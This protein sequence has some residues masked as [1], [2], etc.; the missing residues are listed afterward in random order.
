MLGFQ[1]F[2]HLFVYC[3]Y[4]CRCFV[5]MYTCTTLCVPVFL[6]KNEFTPNEFQCSFA[7][8]CNKDPIIQENFFPKYSRHKHIG[9]KS[10]VFKLPEVCSRL[11]EVNLNQVFNIFLPMVHFRVRPP[12]LSN[13]CSILP[14]SVSKL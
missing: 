2:I 9:K 11:N 10:P 14:D 5:F 12:H 3:F 1:I 13:R 7:S 8:L 6:E 4:M